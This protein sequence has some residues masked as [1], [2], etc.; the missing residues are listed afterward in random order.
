M[1][2]KFFD[3]DKIK[4]AMKKASSGPIAFAFGVGSK[5]S[6]SM[7]AMDPKKSPEFLGRALKM[8]GFS[9]SKIL[10]G[11]AETKGS[12]LIVTT[13]KEV[14]K[15][16]KSIKFFLK[17][18][19][20]K[21]KKVTL[22]GPS[23]EF[24][25]EEEDQEEVE[26]V[27]TD[28]DEE[29][30]GVSF[31]LDKIKVALKK[32]SKGPVSFGFG[33]GSSPAE[34][35]LAMN[36][37]RPP[38]FLAKV[39]KKV[40]FSSSKIL[41][42][43]A[44]TE[45]TTLIIT[46]E[47][48]IPKSKKSIRVFLK[49][50]N[51]RQ[52]KVQLI[53][54]NGEFDTHEDEDDL[55]SDVKAAAGASDDEKAIFKRRFTDASKRVKKVLSDKGDNAKPVAAKFK[56]VHTLGKNGDYG[57]AL[58]HL[59]E[60]DELIDGKAKDSPQ[61][62]ALQEE[63]TKLAKA[64]APKIKEVLTSKAEGSRE[65]AIKFKQAQGFH[66]KKDFESGVAVLG[67]ISTMIENLKG[68]QNEHE[69]EWDQ[70]FKKFE[71]DLTTVLSQ[72]L[73]DSSKL[74]AARDMAIEKAASG[75]HVTALK[76]LDKLQPAVT[77]ALASAKA[78]SKDKKDE[79]KKAK[80][81]PGVAFTQSRLAW[82]GARNKIQ[83]ELASLE[84]AIIEAAKGED[85]EVFNQVKGKTSLLYD[86]LGKRDEVLMDKLDEGL[87]ADTDS[88]AQIKAYG[89]AGKLVEDYVKY[90]NGSPLVQEIDANPFKPVAVKK[91]LDQTLK[92][93]ASRLAA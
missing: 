93:L 73:G 50:N 62:D 84:K 34:G 85:E 11:T 37:K 29:D 15:S 31:D 47:K 2:D 44:R 28:E 70:R 82:N 72:D 39:L 80:I 35:K 8:E 9:T 79:S 43:T 12:M 57:Q 77:K 49:E 23:G 66:S 87:N 1:A 54:P 25:A 86:I 91:T 19:R 30:E 59:D 65:I 20:L 78:G 63:W 14:P 7:L 6:E 38:E 56:Q 51:L 46:C 40:G 45:G 41:I 13:E 68:G 74:R 21:Q 3:I 75:D 18:N 27:V 52:K 69:A 4:I 48:E 26:E 33:V 61:S 42:G 17:D 16:K 64:L 81:A 32:A 67:D 53:G 76:I 10:V 55:D 60:L 88:P 89:E 5:P 90:L 22:M 71:P 92:V 58:T 24:D 83:A 36:I